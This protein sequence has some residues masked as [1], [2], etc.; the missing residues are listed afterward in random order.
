MTP[1]LFSFQSC[2]DLVLALHQNR[3]GSLGRRVRNVHEERI[4]PHAKSALECI[5][6]VTE[7]AQCRQFL[8]LFRMAAAEYA[9]LGPQ[10]GNQV[11]DDVV[12]MLPPRRLAVLL[13]PANAD[14][15]FVGR[16][17]VRQVSKLHRLYD[18]VHDQR[19][20]EPG[21]EPEEQHS[22]TPIA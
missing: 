4:L 19:R 5:S 2:S 17:F 7:P 3:S 18:A 14:V 6:V 21:S 1:W 11:F 9:L 22:A 20:T 16:F 15:V 13:E 12:D 10:R 8:Q